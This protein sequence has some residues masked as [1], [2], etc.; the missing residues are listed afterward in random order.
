MIYRLNNICKDLQNN[1]SRK[2][3]EQ[4]LE[5]NKDFILFKEVLRFLYDKNITTGI[6]IK[7]L[8]SSVEVPLPVTAFDDL[9]ELMEYLKHNNTGSSRNILVTQLSID[10]I[11]N[12]NEEHKN[13][14][15]EIV[16]KSLKLG[17]D[18]KTANKIFG[19]GF[20]PTFDVQLG[21]PIDKCNIPDG[22]EICLTQKLNG[23]RCVY[24]N[25][26]LW[27]RSGKEYTGCK[28]IIDD[29]KKMFKYLNIPERVL[30]GELVLKYC[31]LS[32]SEAFQKGTGIANS[33]LEDKSELKLVIFDT[34]DSTD[35]YLKTCNEKYS[36][37]H[38]KVIEYSKAIMDLG[39]NNIETVLC[40]YKGTDHSKIWEYLEYAEQNDMEGIMINLD[41]PYE[42]KRTK[43]LIK[44][45]AYKDCSLKCIAINIADKGKYKDILGSVTCEYKDWTVNVGSGFTDEQ[46][47]H[48]TQ[49]PE[50]I[51]DKIIEIKYKE[52]TKNKSG[53]E[54]LQFPVF[55]G[56]RFDKTSPDF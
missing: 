15:K 36:N 3:K 10:R 48:F 54:S 17:I 24:Y 25:G 21:T 20:I 28:H 6:D 55:M 49:H 34:I 51:V 19:E 2:V 52:P 13:L 11:S 8:N 41:T 16:T 23:V 26:K 14:L 45:K 40:F 18:V 32:D 5:D 46:R 42:F 39:L 9:S 12:E 1:S 35:F 47:Y 38:N 31:G 56:I 27:S 7:K 43:N 44:V 30:D 29:I 50:E 37:R 22:A 33:D 53:Q 4:I